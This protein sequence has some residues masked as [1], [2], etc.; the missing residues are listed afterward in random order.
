[1]QNTF[2][3]ATVGNEPVPYFLVS[4]FFIWFCLVNLKLFFFDVAGVRCP[5]ASEN[6]CCFYSVE[7]AHEIIDFDSR[8]RS[9]DEWIVERLV[10]LYISVSLLGLSGWLCDCFHYFCWYIDASILYLYRQR[11][12]TKKTKEENKEQ[13]ISRD[14]ISK[15]SWAGT[16]EGAKVIEKKKELPSQR[17]WT[18]FS[19]CV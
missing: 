7:C 12:N 8:W 18:V 17:E 10:K 9:T 6:D 5:A 3:T 1:V 4:G 11:S 13:I 16:T 14:K 15:V 19:M 2:I